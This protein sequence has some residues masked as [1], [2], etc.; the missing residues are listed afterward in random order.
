MADRK[1][2]IMTTIKCE[3][4]RL[5]AAGRTPEVRMAVLKVTDPSGKS[6]QLDLDVIHVRDIVADAIDLGLLDGPPKLLPE[7]TSI[8]ER[9]V[10]K[11]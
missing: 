10:R 5:E 9:L 3:E 6:Y 1:V 2:A 8:G 7:Q 11:P 4:V